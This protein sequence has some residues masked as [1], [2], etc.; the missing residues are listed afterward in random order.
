MS[1][2]R[3]LA[4]EKEL[5]V[6]GLDRPAAGRAFAHLARYLR[7]PLP[8]IA[9]VYWEQ[10]RTSDVQAQL[11]AARGQSDSE[12]NRYYAETPQY[13][14]ELSYWEA[15]KDKQKWFEVLRQ[16][17]RRSNRRQVLDF[18]GGVGGL[19]LALRRGGISC[20][21]LD[22][23]GNTLS[24][25]AWRFEQERFPVQTL[26]ADEPFPREGYDAVFAWDVFEHLYDLEKTLRQIRELLRSGGWL[27]SKSTFAESEQHHIHLEK[28]RIYDDIRVWNGLLE[29]QGFDFVGQLKPGPLSRLLEKTLGWHRPLGIRIVNKLKHGGNFLIHEK[30]RNS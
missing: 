28:N 21:H 18:G 20:D 17:C 25:A 16:V 7:K 5:C 22:V 3:D 29:R 9:K 1:G 23:P 15:T 19:T 11:Q 26:K 14:Y 10:K 6:E 12:V 4:M 8:E 27:V 13:L 24:Y 2:W 30:R